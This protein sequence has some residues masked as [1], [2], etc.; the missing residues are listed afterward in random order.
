MR[1][2]FGVQ[3]AP[4]GRRRRVRWVCAGGRTHPSNAP[5]GA[6]GPGAAPDPPPPPRCVLAALVQL[7]ASLPHGARTHKQP[8]T[9]QLVVRGHLR[10]R[11]KVR[12]AGV[13]AACRLLRFCTR[14]LAAAP[15][16][17]NAQQQR[18]RLPAAP[19]HCAAPVLEP[20]CT[21]SMVH[22]ARSPSRAVPASCCSCGWTRRGG[23]LWGWCSGLCKRLTVLAASGV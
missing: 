4:G 6:G 1:G 18:Q 2:V 12:H 17:Q 8:P 20:P 16:Q 15:R 7:H 5:G 9:R 3:G 11:H 10:Q 13:A 19:V 14:C 22:G 23:W 21:A